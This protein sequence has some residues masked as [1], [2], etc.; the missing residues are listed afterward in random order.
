[1]NDILDEWNVIEDITIDTY[2]CQSSSSPQTQMHQD[3]VDV[4]SGFL[5]WSD[6]RDKSSSFL[7]IV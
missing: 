2:K 7:D 6:A 1:L 3:T 5:S 4:F